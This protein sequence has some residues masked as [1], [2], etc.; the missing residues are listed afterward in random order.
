M[1]LDIHKFQKLNDT[2]DTIFQREDSTWG[3]YDEGW[4]D[5]D[6]IHHPARSS[7]VTAQSKYATELMNDL[8]NHPEKFY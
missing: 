7:A 3:W 2:R 4:Q 1:K 5:G 6:G 8:E